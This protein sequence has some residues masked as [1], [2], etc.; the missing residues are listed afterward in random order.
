M[1][2]ILFPFEQPC[3][4][5][6][7]KPRQC[8]ASRRKKVNV[9][10]NGLEPFKQG[11]TWGEKAR[12][13]LEALV[14]LPSPSMPT[15]KANGEVLGDALALPRPLCRV[16]GTCRLPPRVRVPEHGDP[17]CPSRSMH[18]EMAARFARRVLWRRALEVA[19]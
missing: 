16:A 7:R 3:R 8:G 10:K 13:M 6:G 11:K 9:K 17:R 4:G 14:L 18:W 5:Q 2:D 1:I 12:K 19:P 15:L